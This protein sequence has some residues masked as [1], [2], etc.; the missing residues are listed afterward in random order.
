MSSGQDLSSMNAPTAASNSIPVTQAQDL[1]LRTSTFFEGGKPMN[2]QAAVGDFD[3][4]GMSFGLIQWNF[5]RGTLGPLL[6]QMLQA[7]GAAF[8]GCF[9]PSTDYDTLKS[10]ILSGDIP[11]QMSWARSQQS[12]NT[13]AWKAAFTALGS[14]AKFN[15]I[16][17]QYAI[18]D[19]HANAILVI[20]NLRN[21][22]SALMTNVEVPS[23]VAIFDLCVQ[24]GGIHK[25]MDAIKAKIA[26]TP[27]AFQL[28]LLK[29][30]VQQR[31]LAA[32]PAS[33]ADCMSRRMGI[34]TGKPFSYPDVNG[35]LRTRD[36]PQFGV[37]ASMGTKFVD[38]L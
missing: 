16:Q 15:Q 22:N 8:A 37:I 7:D 11:G 38:G 33:I 5:G 21:L 26:E 17:L 27:P 35:K 24:Q 25:A 34:L 4:Q 6:K 12:A 19:Y 13:T 3:G 1:A 10:A 28:D 29:I 14:N 9:D 32:D 30:A 31:A 36:N 18:H 23:Y 20:A 2:Y